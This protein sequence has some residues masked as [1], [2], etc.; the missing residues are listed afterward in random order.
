MSNNDELRETLREQSELLERLGSSAMQVGTVLYREGADKVCVATPQATLLVQAGPYKPGQMVYILA[1]TGQIW[2]EVST[3][4][5][6]VST[7]AKVDDAGNI[8]VSARGEDRLICGGSVKNLEAGDRVMLD[9]SQSVVMRLIEKKPKPAFVPEPPK[10]QWEGI[11]GCTAAKE[12]L[13][14]AVEMPYK[15]PALYKRYGRKPPKGILFYGPPGCGKT[16]LAKAVATSVAGSCGQGAFVAVKGPEILDP[17]V[18]V[19]EAT[20]RSL[21]AQAR[22]FKASHNRPAVIFVDEAES[23]LGHRGGRYA[24]MERTI[25]PAF[26]TEMDG[27]EDSAAIVILCTNRED[28]LDPAVVRDG[29]IDIK[30]EI[31]RPTYEDALEILAV[32]F[33]ASCLEKGLRKDKAASYVA[34]MLYKEAPQVAPDL[35]YS[36]AALAAIVERATDHALKRDLKSDKFSGISVADILKSVRDWVVQETKMGSRY[37]EAAAA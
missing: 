7:I 8:Y 15:K 26:L 1:E 28:L 18:G 2:G 19:A 22:E 37:A 35:P 33:N 36:G 29:R 11:G 23:I 12:S 6:S 32:H 17:F 31:P 13:L 10:V 9:P 25:V 27:L 14:N 20:V 16:L 34:D 30:I 3:Y 5:G 21:F 4:L 24:Q